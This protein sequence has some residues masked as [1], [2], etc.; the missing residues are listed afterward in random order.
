MMLC[1]VVFVLILM[2]GNTADEVAMGAHFIN[3]L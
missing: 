2:T 1:F 3:M